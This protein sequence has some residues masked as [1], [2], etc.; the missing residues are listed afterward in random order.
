MGALHCINAPYKI[1][2]RTHAEK[3]TAAFSILAYDKE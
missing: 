1:N 3:W 2:D